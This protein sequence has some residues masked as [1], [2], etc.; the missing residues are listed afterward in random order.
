MGVI[1]SEAEF[2]P[3]SPSGAEPG[4][5]SKRWTTDRDNWTSDLQK[6]AQA[7]KKRLLKE[8]K[9]LIR[10]HWQQLERRYTGNRIAL[11]CLSSRSAA[12][13]NEIAYTAR[14]T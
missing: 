10:M 1:E 12:H 6:N 13:F 4:P 11:L 3:L 2:P 9:S 8:H 7:L 14:F 5:R